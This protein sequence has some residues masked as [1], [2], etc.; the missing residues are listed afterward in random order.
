MVMLLPLKSAWHTL[1]TS[2][3]VM[4]MWFHTDATAPASSGLMWMVDIVVLASIVPLG[5]RE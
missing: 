4:K 3:A 5:L 1:A 2:G